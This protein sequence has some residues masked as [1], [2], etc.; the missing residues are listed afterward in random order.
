MKAGTKYRISFGAAVLQGADSNTDLDAY[1]K[2]FWTTDAT[3]PAAPVIA[4]KNANEVTDISFTQLM[5]M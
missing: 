3:A 4:F 5:V 1:L 2:E